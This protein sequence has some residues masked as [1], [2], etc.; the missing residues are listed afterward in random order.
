MHFLNLKHHLDVKDEKL[1][2]HRGVA[3]SQIWQ[4]LMF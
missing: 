4:I 1:E 2:S 3:N